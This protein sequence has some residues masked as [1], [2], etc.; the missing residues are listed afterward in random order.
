MPEQYRKSW[1][2]LAMAEEDFE[3]FID[4]LQWCALIGGV[5]FA[6]SLTLSLFVS[7]RALTGDLGCIG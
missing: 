3:G 7:F 6:V 4:R 2:R 5:S 1:E